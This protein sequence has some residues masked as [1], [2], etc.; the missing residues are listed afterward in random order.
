MPPCNQRC[1]QGRTCPARMQ[2]ADARTGQPL[3]SALREKVQRRCEI[4][5]NF[6]SIPRKHWPSRKGEIMWKLQGLTSLSNKGYSCK[7]YIWITQW[8]TLLNNAEIKTLGCQVD[9]KQKWLQFSDERPP[10]CRSRR[11]LPKHLM[12]LRL[13]THSFTPKKIQISLSTYRWSYVI[14]WKI[15]IDERYSHFAF[16]G[17]RI[18]LR[19]YL[20]FVAPKCCWTDSPFLGRNHI[21]AFGTGIPNA[22]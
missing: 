8:N 12:N 2:R 5:K 4:I 7:K 16:S 9:L 10:L 17:S 14:N 20:G 13:H 21:M 19:H 1:D 3:L 22:L 18:I 6:V 11:G 15:K